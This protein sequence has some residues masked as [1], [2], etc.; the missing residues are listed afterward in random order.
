MID[1]STEVVRVLSL[2]L[3]PPAQS[4]LSNQNQCRIQE[5]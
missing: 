4:K 3:R 5:T 1:A 2:R